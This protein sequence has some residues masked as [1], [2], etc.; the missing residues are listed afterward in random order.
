MT[1]GV[2]LGT[3]FRMF[4]VDI[5]IFI[6]SGGRFAVTEE[7]CIELTDALRRPLGN[8]KP[9]FPCAGGGMRIERVAAMAKAYGQDMI[10]LIG[11]ALLQHSRNLE[12][13]ASAFMEAIREHFGEEHTKV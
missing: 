10:M 5:S 6:N 3:L 8:L 7:E 13:S 11:G 2:L 9:A 1:P 4:G 12:K